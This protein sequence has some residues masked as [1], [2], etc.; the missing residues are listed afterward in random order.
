MTIT[1]T[2]ARLREHDNF[3]ILTHIRPDGDTIGSAAAL[4][5]ALNRAGKCA[6]LYKNPQF[7]D[8]YPWLAEPYIEPDDFAPQF[9]IAV[10]LADVGLLPQGFNGTV[11]LCIDHHPSNSLYAKETLV[12]PEKASCGELILEVIKALCGTID[13]TEADHLY[14]AV[15]TD[16]GCFVYGNTT[17]DTLR[18]GAELCDAGAS[19]TYYNKL[20]FRTSSKARLA[21]EGLIFSSLRY[22]D[23]GK[24]VIAV[25]TKEML[26]KAGAGE[27]D[28]QDIAALPGRVEGAHCSA[29]IK[30]VD[31]NN[32]KISL[33]TTGF[34]NASEVCKQFGGGGHKMA[35]GCAMN[36]SCFEAADILAA[37]IIEAEK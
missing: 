12:W 16:S 10:D 37:A 34:V 24:I 3:L 26:N 31:E 11:D 22:Y 21:L 28:C 6:Y 32:C 18:A 23:N 17:G 27:L 5:H 2:I 7:K 13:V 30:E 4:C 36:K 9:V 20:L 25:V 35:S 8:S 29:V 19:N 14:V 15:S 33:R 1:E